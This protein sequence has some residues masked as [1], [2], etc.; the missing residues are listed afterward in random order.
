VAVVHISEEERDKV[1]FFLAVRA[2]LAKLTKGG[3]PDIAQMNAKVRD[4]I[5]EAI[6][7]DG[8]DEIFEQAQSF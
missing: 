2:I 4:M 6:Q 3:A 8:V 1:H 5:S 7:S